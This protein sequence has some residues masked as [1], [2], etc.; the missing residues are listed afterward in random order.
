[1]GVGDK[2]E[3]LDSSHRKRRWFTRHLLQ[4]FYKWA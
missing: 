4:S 2:T 3:L 1:M